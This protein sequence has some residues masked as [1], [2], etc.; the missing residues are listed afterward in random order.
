MNDNCVIVMV[1]IVAGVQ[2]ES[3]ILQ[4]TFLK[5]ALLCELVIKLYIVY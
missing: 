3:F 1:V 4:C 2:N 5:C